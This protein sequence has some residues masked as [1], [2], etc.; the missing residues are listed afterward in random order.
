MLKIG[1]TPSM[2]LDLTI[3]PD[4][5]QIEVDAQIL[6]LSRFEF[7]FPERRQ[8]FLENSD[9]FENAGFTGSRPFFFK[10]Y[11]NCS[12]HCWNCSKS[13]NIIWSSIEWHAE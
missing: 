1:I 12:G 2:N 10:T 8:F 4:F 6:N 9:L 5:S 7:Q 3:N 13:T 11:W